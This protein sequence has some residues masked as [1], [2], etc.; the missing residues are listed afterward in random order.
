MEQYNLSLLLPRR[1]EAFA[2]LFPPRSI[3]ASSNQQ[4]ARKTPSA[5]LVPW[6]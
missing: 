1:E 3:G 5:L 6:L 2:L 4:M